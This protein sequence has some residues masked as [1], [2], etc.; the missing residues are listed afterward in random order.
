VNVYFI[1]KKDGSVTEKGS[2]DESVFQRMQERVPGEY[3]L[4]DGLTELTPPPPLD[5]PAMMARAMADMQ[6]VDPVL[7]RLD[8]VEKRLAALEAKAKKT[9]LKPAPKG[10]P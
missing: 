3:F 6:Q 4:S 9:P 10:K 8:A 1:R 2:C 5:F 7:Q